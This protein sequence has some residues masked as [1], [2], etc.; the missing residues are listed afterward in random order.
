MIDSVILNS[1]YRR[2]KEIISPYIPIRHLEG[3]SYP[4]LGADELARKFKPNQG[5]KTRN[6][7]A[8]VRRPG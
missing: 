7:K 5:P 4:N 8:A 3:A 6:A 2:E 1:D